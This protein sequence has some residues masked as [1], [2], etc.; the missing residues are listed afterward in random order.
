ML[1]RVRLMTFTGSYENP[2]AKAAREARARAKTNELRAALH[3]KT[4]PELDEMEAKEL[5]EL[6]AEWHPEVFD[7]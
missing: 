6:A 2:Q 4:K 5:A 3:V 1:L 7:E